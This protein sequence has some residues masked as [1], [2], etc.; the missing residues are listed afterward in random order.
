MFYPTA[1]GSEPQDSSIDSY[2]HWVRTM[3]G[4]A[5]ASLIPLVASNRVGTETF[6]NSSITFYGGSFIAGPRGNVVAQVGAAKG[7]LEHGNPDPAP[8]RGEGFVVA[9]FDLDA[10]RVNRLAWGV[11][12]DRRPELYKP[13]V[14]LDGGRHK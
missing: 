7:A 8:D 2:P 6:D 5:A 12:R 4:H 10:L 14:T 1:I 13:L 9:E 11:F 3:L